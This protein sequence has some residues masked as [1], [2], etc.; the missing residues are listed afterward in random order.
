MPLDSSGVAGLACR[1][2]CGR[3]DEHGRR[4]RVE[5]GPRHGDTDRDARIGDDGDPADVMECPRRGPGVH[6]GARRDDECQHEQDDAGR[7]GT[8]RGEL[9]SSHVSSSPSPVSSMSRGPNLSQSR[10]ASHPVA[11]A[12]D[13]CRQLGVDPVGVGSAPSPL[14]KMHLIGCDQMRQRDSIDMRG[15]SLHPIDDDADRRD[16]EQ[17]TEDECQI[18]HD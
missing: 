4:R 11:T 13:E 17:E 2:G 15:G 10:R 7:V 5:V 6:R 9:M 3:I 16:D 14:P 18:C 8:M 1:R 12:G